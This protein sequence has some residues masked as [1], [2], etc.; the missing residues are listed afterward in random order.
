MGVNGGILG[1]SWSARR[2]G[3]APR[4]QRDAVPMIV[5]IQHHVSVQR[6][7]SWA[8]LQA[9][10]IPG[11]EAR[12]SKTRV[13]WLHISDLHHGQ[14]GEAG[15]WPREPILVDMQNQAKRLGSP[16]LILFTGDLAFSGKL[17]QYDKVTETLA[18]IR[19][20]VGGDPVVVPVPGNH[21][22]KRPSKTNAAA[23][24]FASYHKD[25]ELRKSVISRQHRD[26]DN[27]AFLAGL[28]EDYERWWE[29]EVM[30]DW[31]RRGYDFKRG[32]LP[33]DFLLSVPVNG[34]RLGIVGLN[35]A[36]LHFGDSGERKLAVEVEQLPDELT[37]LHISGIQ[38]SMKSIG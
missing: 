2:R 23:R 25:D 14:A 31:G 21:D 9:F 10:R 13:T 34:L 18:H 4:I 8:T 32:L 20:A 11:R 3:S 16:D 37:L 26:E 22:L 38:T 33:G 30:A 6:W 12:M 29:A 1:C 36:F 35:S 15:R 17:D 28:F 7:G 27:V 19:E 5:V 24:M